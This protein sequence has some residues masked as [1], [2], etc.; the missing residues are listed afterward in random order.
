MPYFVG[1]DASK[2][3]THVCVVDRAGAV[4]DTG[5]VETSPKAIAG[6]LR[7]KRRR[8]VRVGAEA[9]A[10]SSWLY[11]G[12]AKAGLP[13]VLIDARHAHG[14]LKNQ[15]NKTDKNDARGIAEM[16]R[17]GTYKA[18]HVKS[19]ASQDIRMLLTARTM[20]TSKA[21]D[22]ANF[23][24]G[25]LL[26]AGLKLARL[27][28]R[29]YE[30]RVRAL[31]AENPSVRSLV[32]TLLAARAAILRER[33][34]IEEKLIAIARADPV[35]LRLMTA[36]GIGELTALLYRCSIDEPRRFPRSRAVGPHL[37]LTPR[38]YQSGEVEWRGRISRSGDGALRRALVTAAMTS[39]KKNTRDSWLK[40]WARDIAER[41]GGMK[42][43]IA[44][45]RRLAV[46]LHRM[47][48]TETDFRWEAP[49][50]A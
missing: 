24:H 20:L 21:H 13:I 8:Y 18:V 39:L 33:D 26:G 7:G 48:V 19:A 44:V 16:M 37:G 50:P 43:G 31:I 49:G 36:P 40:T 42:A 14:L 17:A 9:W 11:E 22:I 1:L 27:Q 10:I 41:R 45:A 32:E 34:G 29:T 23:I 30:V 2:K 12:L 35:C 4:I 47:W 28:R 38:M 6:F 5:V 15:R 3:T 25:V 46:I